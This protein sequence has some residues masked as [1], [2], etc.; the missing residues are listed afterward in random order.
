MS[1]M[2]SDSQL[3]TL[4]TSTLS[5]ELRSGIYTHCTLCLLVHPLH[6]FPAECARVKFIFDDFLIA[7][8]KAE[9]GAVSE[10]PH[11][12]AWCH[13]YDALPHYAMKSD[14]NHIVVNAVILCSIIII[15]SITN[16]R[17]VLRWSKAMPS[18]RAG[19]GA[20]TSRMCVC[21]SECSTFALLFI[22][23]LCRGNPDDVVDFNCEVGK[24]NGHT[25]YAWCI[26][27]FRAEFRIT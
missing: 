4:Y 13:V 20:N 27:L 22:H 21:V 23:D 12:N 16:S 8:P 25:A 11:K 1:E 19:F 2:T 26:D 7:S 18:A 14:F 10:T 5:N 3:Q 24:T 9:S 17:K 6:S 15:I